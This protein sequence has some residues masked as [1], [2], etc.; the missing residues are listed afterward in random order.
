MP[1]SRSGP[2]L[3]CISVFGNSSVEA[4][5]VSRRSR[6]DAFT[7]QFLAERGTDVNWVSSWDG[8]TPLEA[9]RRSRDEDAERDVRQTDRQFD[10]VVT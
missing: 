10:A 1:A 9:A 3:W 8:L 2:E 4:P 5:V 7:A 6:Y